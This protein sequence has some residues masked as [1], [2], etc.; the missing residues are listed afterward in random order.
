MIATI[1]EPNVEGV[2]KYEPAA[3]C[4][5]DQLGF[6][7]TCSV[8]NTVNIEDTLKKPVGVTLI[9]AVKRRAVEESEFDDVSCGTIDVASSSDDE[10]AAPRNRR[11]Q[12]ES[13]DSPT[14]SFRS[15]KHRRQLSETD[16]VVS[17]DCNAGENHLTPVL[18]ISWTVETDG[19]L[20][21]GITLISCASSVSS[22]DVREEFA[23]CGIPTRT[24]HVRRPD[25]G[26]V[27]RREHKQQDDY[28]TYALP[29]ASKPLY[30]GECSE[31]IAGGAVNTLGMFTLPTSEDADC[32]YLPTMHIFYEDRVE[33]VEDPLPKWSA[34]P[35]ASN[36]LMEPSTEPLLWRDV[37]PLGP[38]RPPYPQ[39]YTFSQMSD[40]PPN[41][42]TGT[43]TEEVH[44][45]RIK[46]KYA[47]PR[48]ETPTFVEKEYDIIIV[49]GGHN[50]LITA[51]YLAKEGYD[52]LVLERRHVVGGAAV[53]E[54]L[55]PGY[56]YSRCSY[57]AG[58]LNPEIIKDLDLTREWTGG[59]KYLLRDP[60]SVTPTPMS[61]PIYRGRDA[62]LP[63]FI[64]S[65]NTQ[66]QS[67]VVVILTSWATSDAK[68]TIESIAE[69]S[70]RDAHVFPLY[71][72]L[73]KEMREVLEPL[74]QGCPMRPS[75]AKSIP[76]FVNHSLRIMK[77]LK[78]LTKHS[79]AV[80]DLYELFTAPASQILDRWFETDVLKATLA[81]DAVI[82]S[83]ASPA[84]CGSAYVSPG[85]SG[86][87]S[88]A[89]NLNCG[90]VSLEKRAELD[91]TKA[92]AL[93]QTAARSAL[94]ARGQYSYISP[95]PIPDPSVLLHH[96]LGN[97]NGRQGVWAYV[98][99]GM[100]RI[101]SAIAERA[102]QAG[103]V[104]MTDAQVQRITHDGT[105]ATGVEMSDGT[106]LRARMCV[107]SNATPW[108]TF[109]EL[110]P[111][112]A[113]DRPKSLGDRFTSQIRFTNYSCGAMKINCAV[114]RLPQI[115]GVAPE[116]LQGTVHFETSLGQIEVAAH[117]ARSGIPAT[118]PVVEMTLPSI[119]DSSLVPYNSGHHICQLFVQYAPYDVSPN[120]G[121]WADPG[122][123]ERFVE[124]VFDVIH[125]HDPDFA[126]SVLHKDR[127]INTTF[128]LPGIE[129]DVPM[130]PKL[131][132]YG[133]ATRG[134]GGVNLYEV[135][136]PTALAADAKR[137]S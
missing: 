69:F 43:L 25:E 73:L 75:D 54:E 12:S 70:E 46:S 114:D 17:E 47:A 66:S 19:Y 121:S 57:L 99:G 110:L 36:G 102:M 123:V 50:G 52:V 61:H 45:A 122:F 94:K 136:G 85:Q 84:D 65:F 134:N 124:R 115:P 22:R 77:T 125:E 30:C 15:V 10:P 130:T 38:S 80:P 56:K 60:G 11:P 32:E 51:A 21:P 126:N 3:E 62:R 127:A 37:R 72:Q 74:M 44:D 68:K 1:E 2:V 92:V 27:P 86:S 39:T 48:N 42:E 103:A 53:T 67:L 93:P 128:R 133:E 117:E 79:D 95:F 83:M 88:A 49:G 107:V 87:S 129:R 131:L 82:G 135:S 118:R 76:E 41:Y 108:H 13:M 104:I 26:S 89:V 78:R 112:N 24:S 132:A 18:L 34:L 28:E 23:D 16:S 91:D 63:V 55:F 20:S 59:F 119:L 113:C 40:L 96:V 137:L 14:S 111:L 64:D 100:G 33:D 9:G 7:P 8:S 58:L 105:R 71:E 35:C 4:E 97:V 5:V 90:G 31:Y 81:T 29:T 116:H 6:V 101:S 106:Q 120:H 109:L 98:E